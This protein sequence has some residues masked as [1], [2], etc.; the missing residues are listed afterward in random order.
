MVEEQPENLQ[1]GHLE[2]G[3]WC[4]FVQNKAPP[5]LSIATK[6]TAVCWHDLDKN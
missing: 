5:S 6:Q 2:T 4:G 3:N 1:I